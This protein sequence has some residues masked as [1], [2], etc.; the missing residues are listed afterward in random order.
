MLL[1]SFSQRLFFFSSFLLFSFICFSSSLPSHSLFSP[2]D[3]PRFTCPG[4]LYYYH[5]C[6][7]SKVLLHF[8]SPL[9]LLLHLLHSSRLISFPVFSLCSVLWHLVLS[10][11]RHYRSPSAAVISHRCITTFNDPLL[12]GYSDTLLSSYYTA[13]QH[14]HAAPSL[15][16]R[17]AGPARC[18]IPSVPPAYAPLTVSSFSLCLPPVY[19]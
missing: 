2:D 18:V 11:C 3:P 1:F 7:L 9:L 16:R 14:E 13:V 19:L 10:D 6:G 15:R 12:L 17:L 5:Y 8:S 4:A